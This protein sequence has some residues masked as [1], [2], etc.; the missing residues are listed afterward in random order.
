MDKP[1]YNGNRK[2]RR[3][4]AA[5][6]TVTAFAN[7][8]LKTFSSTGSKSA[9][10]LPQVL[11]AALVLY[12]ICLALF[13]RKFSTKR[14]VAVALLFLYIGVLFFLTV[15][16]IPKD[17]WHIMP[18]ATDWVLHS[19][20][21]VP[22]VSGADI[23]RSATASGNWSE[24]F[25]VVVGNAMVFLPLGILIPLSNPKIRFRG[26]LLFAILIPLCLEGLQLITNIL[27]GKEVRIVEAEDVILNAAGCLLGYLLFALIRQIFRPKYHAKHYA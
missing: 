17:H 10:S 7:M 18:A 21:W 12:F 11:A 4:S 25:R 14:N 23:F 13:F 26:M 2:M 16:V 15:P 1:G 6:N 8:V 19:I 22:F 3:E 5:M 27:A 20:V 24:F 9:L